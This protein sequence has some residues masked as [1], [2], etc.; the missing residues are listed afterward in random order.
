M[1]VTES[2]VAAPATKKEE[3]D[4]DPSPPVL[5]ARVLSAATADDRAWRPTLP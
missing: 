2:D 5:V 1:E 3:R 4:T